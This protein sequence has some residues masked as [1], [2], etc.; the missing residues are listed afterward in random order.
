V[1]RRVKYLTTLLDLNPG[2]QT[3]LTDLLTKGATAN[4]SFASSMRAARQALNTAEKNNDSAGIQ[5]ASAQ[6]GTLTGQEALNRANFNA[7]IAQIFTADQL[8]KYKALGG[9]GGP[10]RGF[11][12]RGHFQGNSGT[13]TPQ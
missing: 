6:I 10:G 11:G 7:A 8:T 13:P 2:Q 12:G 4:Q 1:Q 3:S 9:G 5:T